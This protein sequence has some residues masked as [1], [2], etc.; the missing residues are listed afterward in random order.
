[1]CVASSARR[2]DGDQTLVG[3]LW[4]VSLYHFIS[5]RIESLFL[6][7]IQRKRNV[8]WLQRC[9]FNKPDDGRYVQ[10]LV[11][12][13]VLYSPRLQFCMIYFRSDTPQMLCSAYI[14]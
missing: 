13:I 4:S 11:K 12:L 10:T 9:V 5:S 7:T 8:Y 2:R 3:L 1:M 6:F 14:L